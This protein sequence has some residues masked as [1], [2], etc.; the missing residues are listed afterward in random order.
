MEILSPRATHYHNRACLPP[1]YMPFAIACAQL[2]LLHV[3]GEQKR[4]QSDTK[5]TG[6]LNTYLPVRVVSFGL[7][8]INETKPNYFTKGVTMP[9]KQLPAL[10]YHLHHF[11][12][13]PKTAWIRLHHRH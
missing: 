11:A 4:G 8:R 1:Q 5:Q 7:S 6:L 3:C 12:N 10:R 9:F 13:K 2:L